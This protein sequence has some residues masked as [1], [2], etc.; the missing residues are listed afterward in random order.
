M[1]KSNRRKRNYIIAGLCMILLIMVVGYAAF[2]SQLKISGTSNISSSFLVKITNIEVSNIVGGAKDKSEVTTHTD[3]TATFGT[4]L[5]SPGDSITY[6]ITIENQGTIYAVL[7]TINKTDTSN[8]A[9]LFETSGVFEGDALNAGG[10]ATMQVT[11]TYNPN[12]T[13]QP[14]DLDSNLKIDLGYEQAPEGYVPPVRQIIVGGQEVEIVDSGD[15]LY[16]DEYEYGK[17]TYKGANPNNYITFN[18][19]TW[20]IISISPSGLIKIMRNE[21]IGNMAWDTKFSNDW[22]QSSTLKSYLNDDYLNSITINKDKI[23]E[24]VYGIGGITDENNNLLEQI[25]DE[26]ETT[27]NGSVGLITASEYLRANTNTEQ[28]G[29]LSLNNTNNRNCLTTNWIYKIVP[30]SS[31]LWLLS[32]DASSRNIFSISDYQ[33]VPGSLTSGSPSNVKAVSPA[34]YLTATTTLSGTGTQSDPYILS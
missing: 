15:G 27:W 1:R 7:K 16:K 9:I 20:R 2:S 28:C 6:D 31:W 24:G 34:L 4:T 21:S 3:T 11:V 10:I 14:D 17:Y 29:S 5:Q 26:N 25:T 12:I 30:N 8:S 18:N 33:Y 32:H 22:N 13:T 23:V 19:E